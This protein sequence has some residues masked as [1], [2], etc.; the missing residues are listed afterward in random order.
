MHR[1]FAAFILSV[2]IGPEAD[3]PSARK[4]RLLVAG[5]MQWRIALVVCL[6]N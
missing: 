4:R 6:L 5:K 1:R 3:E 2:Q